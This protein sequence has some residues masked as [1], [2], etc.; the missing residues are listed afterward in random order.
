MVKNLFLN[1]ICNLKIKTVEGNLLFYTNSKILNLDDSF[2]IFIDAKTSQKMCFS[3][4]Q[5]V[6]IKEVQQ[7]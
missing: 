3:L 7:Q 4:S 5:L 2:I 1:K 6:E